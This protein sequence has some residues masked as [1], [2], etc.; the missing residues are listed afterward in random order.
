M[1]GKAYLRIDEVAQLLRC[2]TITVRR[3]V[4]ARRLAVHKPAGLRGRTLISAVDLESYLNRCRV[5]AVGEAR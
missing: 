3:A 2:S 5:A 4:A 1:L